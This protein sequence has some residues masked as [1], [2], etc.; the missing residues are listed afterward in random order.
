[1]SA[2]LSLVCAGKTFSGLPTPFKT[3][4]LSGLATVLQFVSATAALE[5]LTVHVP[6]VVEAGPDNSEEHVRLFQAAVAGIEACT[7]RRDS[8]DSSVQE[9]LLHGVARIYSAAPLAGLV[10]QGG[11]ETA[12]MLAAA[13]SSLPD[14]TVALILHV[15]DATPGVA[16][17]RAAAVIAHLITSAK[18]PP[19]SLDAVA[20][21]L[22]SV[23]LP[24]PGSVRLHVWLAD[25]R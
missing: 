18:F 7:Q 20:Q 3:G 14:D 19:S 22:F 16:V 17:A 21:R 2:F 1:M 25:R 6:M 23:R 8:F 12:R 9:G 11:N 5:M 15:D 13:V 4:L 24:I 10:G